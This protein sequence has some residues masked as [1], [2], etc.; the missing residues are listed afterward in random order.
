[1]EQAYEDAGKSIDNP[2]QAKVDILPSLLRGG[3]CRLSIGRFW[4]N[5][6]KNIAMLGSGSVAGAAS[7]GP[8]VREELAHSDEGHLFQQEERGPGTSH[9]NG[10]GVINKINK[11]NLIVHN[12]SF[13][14]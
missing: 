7:P 3:F 5:L 4:G 6:R 1:M 10:S 11:T 12:E 14:S 9:R 13:L 2:N 8:T